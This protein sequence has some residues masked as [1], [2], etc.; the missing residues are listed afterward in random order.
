[1]LCSDLAWGLH[2]YFSHAQVMICYIHISA[3][4][5]IALVVL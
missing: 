3:C 5:L 2:V 1:M 4:H